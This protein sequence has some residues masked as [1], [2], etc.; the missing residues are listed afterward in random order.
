[1]LLSL[2]PPD[3]E[4]YDTFYHDHGRCYTYKPGETED[5]PLPGENWGY[6]L[7]FYIPNLRDN[8]LPGE[9]ELHIHDANEM[10]RGE[11]RDGRWR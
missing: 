6:K 11:Q 5:K 10:W 7:Y 8:M 3:I 4:R 9:W 1:M 2:F